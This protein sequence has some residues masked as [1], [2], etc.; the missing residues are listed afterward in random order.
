MGHLNFPHLSICTLNPGLPPHS[1]L[2]YKDKLSSPP[3]SLSISVAFFGRTGPS[4]LCAC[5]L[6][7]LRVGTTAW[8]RCESFSLRR[9]P[10]LL[11]MGSSSGRSVVAAHWAQLPPGM[12]DLPRPGIESVSPAFQEDSQPLDHQGS[13]Q[14]HFLLSFCYK[15]L[16]MT[17]YKLGPQFA[18]CKLENMSNQI[19]E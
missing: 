4:L 18:K 13:P 5:F 12:W 1:E 16:H 19:H 8:L 3:K 10:L 17:D 2:L 14:V 15:V 7:F 9:L 11:S 6:Q